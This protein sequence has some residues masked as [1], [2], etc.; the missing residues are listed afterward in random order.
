MKWSLLEN[1]NPIIG[2]II[3]DW[4]DLLKSVEVE[5][6]YHSF[7]KKHANLFFINGF[8]Q[9]FAISKLKLSS[10][11]ETD[12]AV[13]TDERSLGLTWN[14]IEIKTPHA[15]VYT[16]DGV[17][18]AT[19]FKAIQQV[20]DWKHWLSNNRY[21]VEKLFHT[22]GVR[23]AKDPNFRFTII[24]GNRE[25]NKKYLSKRNNLL[26]SGEVRIRSFD[27]LTDNLKRKYY[28]DSVRLLDGNWDHFHE[29]ERK[30]LANPFLEALTD[31][32]W[33]KITSNPEVTI[34]H[35]TTQS[36]SILLKYLNINNKR[37]K[38]FQKWVNRS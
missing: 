14:F 34:P 8:D 13:P 27:Y 3:N 7:I 26:D 32:Q 28:R 15:K 5:H 16:K 12:F 24:I 21:E 17:P 37:L 25:N 19:L 29:K 2:S 1:A 18:S 38:Q 33:K 23:V 35:F 22:M 6:S 4:E 20:S 10:G 30:M 9:F 36:A 11:L 31:S